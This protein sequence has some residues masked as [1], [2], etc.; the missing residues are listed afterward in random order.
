M[1][2]F[3]L[4][5]LLL[6]ATTPC[7]A[8]SVDVTDLTPEIDQVMQ[9]S[10]VHHTATFV[11][12]CGQFDEPTVFKYYIW[13]EQGF[14]NP[15]VIYQSNVESVTLQPGEILATSLAKLKYLP[16]SGDYRVCAMVYAVVDGPNPIDID[17]HPYFVRE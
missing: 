2:A 11:M 14:D 1:K 3:V 12:E 6:V 13:I 8:V 16:A 5:V 10:P 9:G 17:S 4:T 7:Q 15:S